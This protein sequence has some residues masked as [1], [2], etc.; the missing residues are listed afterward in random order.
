[1]HCTEQEQ[2]CLQNIGSPPPDSA[3][4]RA[5]Q[6]ADL[7]P[8]GMF[9]GVGLFVGRAGRPRTGLDFSVSVLKQDLLGDSLMEA[10]G[11]RAS[12]FRVCSSRRQHQKTL[13]ANSKHMCRFWE[14]VCVVV[15]VMRCAEIKRV[16]SDIFLFKNLNEDAECELGSWASS[17][18]PSPNRSRLI[19]RCVNWSSR[20]LPRA[21]LSHPLPSPTSPNFTRIKSSRNC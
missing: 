9:R 11:T 21:A 5:G 13:F 6:P 7:L 8:R 15:E 12:V 10:S 14:R 1:M 4:Q 20:F 19:G 17:S 2:H 16:L 3:Q 18:P